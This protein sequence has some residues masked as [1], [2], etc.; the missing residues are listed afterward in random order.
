MKIDLNGRQPFKER[1]FDGA[2]NLKKGGSF[3]K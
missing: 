3:G 1:N 2:N